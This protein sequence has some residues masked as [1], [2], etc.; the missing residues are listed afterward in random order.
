MRMYKFIQDGKE[1]FVI[2][3]NELL[4]RVK[5]KVSSESELVESF[6]LNEDWSQHET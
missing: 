4:A 3:E 2:A 1:V 5:A 6:T